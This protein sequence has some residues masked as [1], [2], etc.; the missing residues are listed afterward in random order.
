MS[1]LISQMGDFALQLMSGGRLEIVLLIVLIVVGLILFLV[2]LWLLW[3]LL[4]LLGK[5]LLW[6][7]KRGGESA[8]Q[9]SVAR[10]EA[11]LGKP[12]A[13]STGWGSSSSIRLRRALSEARRMAGSDALC[14]VVVAGDGIID[15]CRSLGLTPPSVGMVGIAAGGDVIL[16]DATRCDSRMLGKLARAL[17]WRRPEADCGYSS[18]FLRLFRPTCCPLWRK[19]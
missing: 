14:I 9:H 2:L 11:K 13:V 5:G 17:P 16:I 15:L 3:K 4:V 8:Q 19:V 18:S 1:S 12:P 7:F 10:R 6:L